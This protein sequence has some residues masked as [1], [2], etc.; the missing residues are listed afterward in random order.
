MYSLE[1]IQ[2]KTVIYFYLQ[3]NS[4]LD[5][6]RNKCKFC[7][8]LRCVSKL[9]EL[10][11]LVKRRCCRPMLAQNKQFAFMDLFGN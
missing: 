4:K 10:P 2:K 9:D 1:L 11:S 8:T 5:D 6:Y 7:I 3:Q